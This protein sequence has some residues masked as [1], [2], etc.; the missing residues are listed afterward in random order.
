MGNKY[1]HCTTFEQ[2]AAE[3][4]I[5]L[6]ELW[7]LARGDLSVAKQIAEERECVAS[8]KVAAANVRG[9]ERGRGRRVVG[10]GRGVA[11]KRRTTYPL[12]PKGAPFE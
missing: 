11:D 9:G 12:I 4:P 2:L 5:E 7:E 1:S 6:P 3:G 8:A 10:R